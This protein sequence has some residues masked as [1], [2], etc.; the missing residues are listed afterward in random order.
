MNAA[1]K[2]VTELARNEQVIH[3]AKYEDLVKEW[4]ARKDLAKSASGYVAVGNDLAITRKII[5]DFGLG[6][7]KRYLEPA[8]LHGEKLQ[9]DAVTT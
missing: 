9:N 3:I 1:D 6:S 7:R 4:E 2:L 5:S 8:L